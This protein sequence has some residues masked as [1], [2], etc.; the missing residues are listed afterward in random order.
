[1]SS[2]LSPRNDQTS[3]RPEG[4]DVYR[5]IF[6]HM[7]DAVLIHDRETQK[8]LDVNPAATRRYGFTKDQML[9]MT[10]VELHPPEERTRVRE[11]IEIPNPAEPHVFQHLTGDGRRLVVEILSDKIDYRNR[12][13]WLSI[14]RDVT[15]RFEG[16][17]TIEQEAPAT[18]TPNRAG[19]QPTGGNLE[20][21]DGV[22][23]VQPDEKRREAFVAELESWGLHAAGCGSGDEALTL[24]A[25]SR[26]SGPRWRGALVDPRPGGL[27][28]ASLGRTLRARLGSSSPLLLLTPRPGESIDEGRLQHCGFAGA[29]RNVE[30]LENYRLQLTGG[31]SEDEVA[32]VVERV[33]SAVSAATEQS[34][35][36]RSPKRHA[37]SATDGE[38]LIPPRILVVEDNP[39]NQKVVC[40]MLRRLGFEVELAENG[41]EGVDRFCEQPYDLVLMDCQMPVMDGYEATRNIRQVPGERSGT[42]IVALTAN[43]MDGDRD[44]CLGAGMDDYMSKPAKAEDLEQ[45]M[46][47]WIPE[48][49]ARLEAAVAAS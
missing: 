6:E 37:T 24:I 18:E 21:V 36:E 5:V 33:Q 29:V 41:Q 38:S 13:A 40:Y 42:P 19:E 31:A 44:K 7:A 39:V 46:H 17:A 8:F 22:L 32:D 27:D 14:V 34:N 2:D 20:R 4:E 49:A 23:V 1:M 43:A 15:G 47:R 11:L 26:G 3:D 28:G 10:P 35:A 16:P 45:M 25:A 48:C 12:P 9:T 30:E